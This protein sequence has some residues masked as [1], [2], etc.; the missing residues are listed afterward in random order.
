MREPQACGK[1][2]SISQGCG[3][4]EGTPHLGRGTGPYNVEVGGGWEWDEGP[5][6]PGACGGHV[7]GE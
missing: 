2:G 1:R 7:Q 5:L 6:G 3:Q 4:D